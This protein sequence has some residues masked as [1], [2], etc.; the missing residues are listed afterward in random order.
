MILTSASDNQ[1]KEIAVLSKPN[2]ERYCLKQN[3]R[4]CYW[5]DPQT[6][7]PGSWMKI[8]ILRRCLEKFPENDWVFWL[9]GDMLVC[10]GGVDFYSVV[11]KCPDANLIAGSDWNGLCAAVLGVRQC[12]WSK[13]FLDTL[14]LCGDGPD[15]PNLGPKREQDTIKHLCA[16]FPEITARIATPPELEIKSYQENTWKKGDFLLHFP[17]A[18]VEQ[19]VEWMRSFIAGT[20]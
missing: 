16:I 19:R 7:R 12:Q 5:A 2:F 6:T 1:F 13:H 10:D 9:D 3:Y 17:C 14:L 18:P 20:L 4:F 8:D 15:E 11:E